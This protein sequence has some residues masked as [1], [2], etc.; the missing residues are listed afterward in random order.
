[1]EQKLDADFEAVDCRGVVERGVD[2][3]KRNVERGS[4]ARSRHFTGMVDTVTVAL[5]AQA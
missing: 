4:A 2:F 5:T 3:R 1:L